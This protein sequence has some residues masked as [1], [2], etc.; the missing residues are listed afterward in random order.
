M[1]SAEQYGSD[2]SFDNMTRVTEDDVVARY[3]KEIRQTPP[4]IQAGAI[5]KRAKKQPEKEQTKELSVDEYMHKCH[6]RGVLENS[7]IFCGDYSSNSF[8]EKDFSAWEYSG[9]ESRTIEKYLRLIDNVRNVVRERYS[10]EK[11][12]EKARNAFRLGDKANGDKT[13]AQNESYNDLK[14]ILGFACDYVVLQNER[15]LS[16]IVPRIQR[17]CCIIDEQTGECKIKNF[18]SVGTE[19]SAYL[20]CMLNMSKG[21]DFALDYLELS[22]AA[23]PSNAIERDFWPEKIK[24]LT[25]P[26]IVRKYGKDYLMRMK[27][28]IPFVFKWFSGKIEVKKREPK[29]PVGK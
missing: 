7:S 21:I 3:L 5:I 20:K 8:S 19:I 18:A 25:S 6:E 12:F 2:G 10:R 16:G 15:N 23:F 1:D 26:E 11:I 28:I 4:K 9:E 13:G 24:Y 14:K 29:L 22:A 27:E 17:L